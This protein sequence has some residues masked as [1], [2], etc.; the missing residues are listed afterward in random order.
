MGQDGFASIYVPEGYRYGHR[1]GYR[2]G[3]GETM[4]KRNNFTI[5]AN[6]NELI[7]FQGIAKYRF[8]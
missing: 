5:T 3:T 1:Y 2:F 8:W 4:E 6:I 7:V